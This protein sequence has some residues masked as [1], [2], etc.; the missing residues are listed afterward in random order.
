MK[1]VAFLRAVNVGGTAKI[2]MAAL[3]ALA[4]EIG[5]SSPETL[6]QSGNLV[7]EAG[8]KS[9]G[10]LEKLLEREI[11]GRLGVETDV[12]VR[13]A[14]DLQATIARN[15]FP[16]EANSDPGFVHV[17]FLKAPASAAQVAAL[18]AA[19]KGREAVKSAGREVF[20]HYPDGAGRSKLTGAVV[21]R[22]LGAR[23]TSRNWNTVTK[24]AEMTA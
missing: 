7:F 23:G 1:A 14:K 9:A 24:L 5:L 2:A 10:A 13:T 16:K 18:S 17:H 19:I 20:L 3:K 11:A 12:M 4:E 15:P 21:E 22:H 8:T 6:L